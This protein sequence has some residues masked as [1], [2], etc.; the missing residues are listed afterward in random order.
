MSN[1]RLYIVDTA[2]SEYCCIAKGHGYA[3]DL[4]NV[5]LLKSFLESRPSEGDHAT[6]LIL[7]DEFHRDYEKYIAQGHNVNPSNTWTYL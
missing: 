6:D 4:G 5:L 2:T 3:W 1:N 7:I